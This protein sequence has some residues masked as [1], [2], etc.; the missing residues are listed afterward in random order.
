M[1][2]CA[3]VH[4]VKTSLTS[5]AHRTSEQH[6]EL[7]SAHR[8]QDFDD[9]T[10]VFNWVSQ[11]N[12]F[13]PSQPEPRSLSSGLRASDGDGLNCGAVEEI[14]QSI[15][16]RLNNVNILGCSLKGSIQVRTLVEFEKGVKIDGENIHVDPNALF[17]G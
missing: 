14:G 12:P 10:I 1:H 6:V 15:Q 9:M 11:H 16:K 3:Q 13:N 2:S 17:R 5:L 4:D 8:K 7:T